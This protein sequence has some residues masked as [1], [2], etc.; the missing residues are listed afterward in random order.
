MHKAQVAGSKG[1]VALVVDKQAGQRGE[2]NPVAAGAS[3][4]VRDGDQLERL[5]RQRCRLDGV[6]T[7]AQRDR[8]DAVGNADEVGA[9]TQGGSGHGFCDADGVVAAA[10]VDVGRDRVVSG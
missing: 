9:A 7:L 10:R 5:I 2:V 4:K 3:H 1:V 8:G 6:A